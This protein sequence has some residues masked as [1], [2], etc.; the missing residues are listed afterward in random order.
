M[1]TDASKVNIQSKIRDLSKQLRDVSAGG[2]RRFQNNERYLTLSQF[3]GYK[4]MGRNT[5]SFATTLD[6]GKQLVALSNNELK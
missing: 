5:G 2:N 4:M 6:D 1:R 3:D